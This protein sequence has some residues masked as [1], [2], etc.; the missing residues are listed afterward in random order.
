LFG[1][2]HQKFPEAQQFLDLGFAKEV[3]NEKDLEL[4]VHHFMENQ[5]LLQRE[6]LS[7]LDQLR[8]QLPTKL[9]A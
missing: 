2:K 1:P 6:I 3:A 7:E 9:L 4:A 5:A 8:V